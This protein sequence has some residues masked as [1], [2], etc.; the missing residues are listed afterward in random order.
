MISSSKLLRES[1]GAVDTSG[2]KMP[3]DEERWKP[4]QIVLVSRFNAKYRISSLHDDTEVVAGWDRPWNQSDPSIGG[5][6]KVCDVSLNTF[7][8]VLSVSPE[9]EKKPS[10]LVITSAGMLV[11]L[12]ADEIDMTGGMRPWL[13]E[14]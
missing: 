11:F 7:V 6:L 3:H 10:A 5:H 2:I 12:H 4:G 13:E 1:C 8:F 14:W 9:G